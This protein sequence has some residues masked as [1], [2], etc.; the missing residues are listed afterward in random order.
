M[1]VV[2]YTDLTA[3]LIK[4]TRLNAIFQAFKDQVNGL[5]DRT[6]IATRFVDHPAPVSVPLPIGKKAAY[7]SIVG[8]G[9]SLANAKITGIGI[10]SKPEAG[11]TF[12][13][14]IDV[15]RLSDAALVAHVLAG[16][17]SAAGA[18]TRAYY[19]LAPISWDAS[20]HFIQIYVSSDVN[21]ADASFFTAT[22]HIASEVVA[23]GEL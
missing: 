2:I 4:Y 14:D 6:N 1:A 23:S 3:E 13:W 8:G 20:L 5:L 15:L 9:T 7:A 17:S 18:Q 22:P 12:S 21:F 11:M 19:D 10:Y 16:T